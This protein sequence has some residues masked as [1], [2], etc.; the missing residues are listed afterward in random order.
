MCKKIK[1]AEKNKL[2]NKILKSYANKFEEA[3]ENFID[4]IYKKIEEIDTWYNELNC[5]EDKKH[6]KLSFNEIVSLLKENGNLNDLLEDI[7]DGTSVNQFGENI[8]LPMITV[9]IDECSTLDFLKVP[10]IY[11][12]IKDNYF[13]EFNN[14]FKDEL[15][16]S[17]DWTIN[18]KYEYYY[19]AILNNY[20]DT[21]L[22]HTAVEAYDYYITKPA[23]ITEKWLKDEKIDTDRILNNISKKFKNKK[24]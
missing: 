4:N 15:K 16:P 2:L 12:H 8:Y 21:V 1:E 3:H 14:V 17:N 23:Y 5:K 22:D 24:L 10:S 9:C 19:L 6:N 13:N 18:N 11:S 20:I 7:Y